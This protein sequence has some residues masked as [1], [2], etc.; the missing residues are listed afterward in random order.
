[1]LKRILDYF[2]PKPHWDELLRDSEIE[3]AVSLAMPTIVEMSE[4]EDVNIL[5]EFDHLGIEDRLGQ[6]ILQLAPIVSTRYLYANSGIYF[7]DEY[8]IG[9]RN[10]KFSP[11]QFTD[12]KISRS[13]QHFL[14][15]TNL[16]EPSLGLIAS[17]S[18]GFELIQQ[19]VDNGDDLSQVVMSSPLMYD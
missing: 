13:I 2:K 8:V 6:R 9:R 17:R 5:L 11:V 10:G 19:F 16:P 14:A 15:S 18:A 12:D 4:K 3:D 1:M 7:P